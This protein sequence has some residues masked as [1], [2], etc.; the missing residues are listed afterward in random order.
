MR[1]VALLVNP[2]AGGGRAA[3]ALPAVEHALRGHDVTFRT[4]LTRDLPHARDLARAAAQAGETIVTL[5]GDGLAGTVAA[6]LRE[7]PGGVLGVLPGGRGN[8]L[9]RV[10]GIPLEP[11]AACAVVAGGIE[12]ALD[13][14]DVD[15]RTFLGIASLGFDS[16]VNRIANAAPSAL[17]KLVYTYAALRALPGWRPAAFAL[18]LDG[19]RRDFTGYSVACAN[20]RAYGGGMLLA[21]G[22][23]L[24][25]GLLDV[26]ITEQLPKW[27]FLRNLPRVFRGTHLRL[28]QVRV[29]RAREVRVG[30]DR[31][32][33]VYA[34]GD[35]V[36]DTPVT[37]RA[38]PR[39]IRVLVPG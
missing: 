20:A 16:D 3:R 7:T 32:F 24:D 14:G 9:C 18:E 35:P 22:A 31:P 12:R 30:A 13:V 17:G 19:R 37:I 25:D 28:P 33:A 38:I 2:S 6:I 29:E 39:A 27:R 8:D 34:D 11:V 23:E 10:L 1:R 5:S 36:A 21:P 4:S 15:G 26:V